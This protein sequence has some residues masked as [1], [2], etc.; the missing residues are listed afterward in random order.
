MIPDIQLSFTGATLRPLSPNDIHL[1]YVEGLNDPDVNRYLDGVKRSTQTIQS[2]IDFVK[3]NSDSSDCILWGIWQ[4]GEP[5]HCGTV[6]LH[7]INL[8][9]R[10]ANIG[11]CLFEKNAWG[12]RIGSKAI[13]VVT[14]WA[15]YDLNLRWVEAAAYVDNI[16]S[17]KA[18]LAAGYAWIYDIPKKYLLDGIPTTAKVFVARRDM[19]DSLNFPND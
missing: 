15:L 17:Q 13:D 18:F 16:A 7:G 19:P 10:T 12:K 4:E 14:Q 3:G 9:H 5:Y 6:R 1:G 11:V 8:L 2:V